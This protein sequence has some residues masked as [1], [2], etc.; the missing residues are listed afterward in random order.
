MKF[1]HLNALS[2]PIPIKV[3][4]DVIMT[5][6]PDTLYCGLAHNL[7]GFENCDAPKIY[8]HFIRGKGKIPVRQ[9]EIT[10]TYPKCVHSLILRA[11]PGNRIPREIPALDGARLT[12]RFQ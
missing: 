7:H 2:S 1:F 3:H 5:V 12:L 11:V 4:F 10:G 6:I 8:R 9:K